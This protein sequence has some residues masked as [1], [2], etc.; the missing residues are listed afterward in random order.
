MDDIPLLAEGLKCVLWW[1]ASI[2]RQRQLEKV[3]V[4]FSG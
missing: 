4:K 1:W 2:D 3:G